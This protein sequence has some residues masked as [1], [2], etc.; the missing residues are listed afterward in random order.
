MRKLTKEFERNNQYLILVSVCLNL[1][2]NPKACFFAY[3][4]D[5]FKQ[6][7]LVFLIFNNKCL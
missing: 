7:N 4:F 1:K 6:W 5:F 2:R 3:P